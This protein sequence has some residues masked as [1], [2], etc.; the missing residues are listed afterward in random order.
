MKIYAKL[1]WDGV[2]FGENLF[3]APKS[4]EINKNLINL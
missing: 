2:H 4:F 1:I 3:Y